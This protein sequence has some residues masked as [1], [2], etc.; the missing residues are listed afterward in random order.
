MTIKPRRKL[1]AKERRDLDIEI[2]FMERLVKRD[3]QYVEALQILSADYTKRGQ[4]DDGLKIDRKLARLVPTD[5][6]IL[7]NLA[8][9]LSL[10]KHVRQSA[11]ALHKAIDFGFNEFRMILRDPDLANLRRDP[12]FDKIRMRILVREP[13]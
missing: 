4:F 6:T 13:R 12:L 3:P 10:T 7:Y 8:C 11:V 9:S 1:T 5:S 2:G